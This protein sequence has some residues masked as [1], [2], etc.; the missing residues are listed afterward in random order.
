MTM[1]MRV[2]CAATLLMAAAAAAAADAQ[3]DLGQWCQIGL[4][5]EGFTCDGPTPLCCG[6]NNPSPTCMKKDD[7]CFP[8]MGTQA[9]CGPAETDAPMHWDLP[10]GEEAAT[11][12]CCPKGLA[13]CGVWD[14]NF[15]TNVGTCCHWG[16]LCCR[17][18]QGYYHCCPENT[19]C[20]APG[21][22]NRCEPKE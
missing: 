11:I 20:G 8:Y 14:P 12:G 7:F 22:N 21:S 16:E 15:G 5:G 13:T 1:T 18:H 19:F 4:G 9:A 2:A 6:A 17:D 10:N 3:L